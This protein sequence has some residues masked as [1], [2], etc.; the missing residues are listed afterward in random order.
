MYSKTI[1]ALSLALIIT[2]SVPTI[3]HATKTPSF[4]NIVLLQPNG[5]SEPELSIGQ[6]GQVV[7]VAL[8]WTLFQTN[9]WVGAFGQTPTFQG[10]IDSMIQNGIGGGEDADVDFGSTGTV[11]VTS[12]LAVFNPVTNVVQLGVSAITCPNGDLSNNFAKCTRQILDFTQAD[13][14]WI[15]SDGPH[16]WISYHDSGSSTL[17]HVWRSDDD[18]FTWKT[19]GDPIP[20][21][22]SATGNSTF[23]N[24]Q[25][26][27]VADPV[28]HNVYD[29]FAAGVS[30]VQKGT[31]ANFNNIYVSVSTDLGATWTPHL[32]FSAPVN[33]ALNN[34][35]PVLADDPSSG[36]LY[37]G[38]SNLHNVYVSK[39]TNQ[40]STWTAP[41]AV[42]SSPVNTALMP[43]IAVRSGTVDVVYYGTSAASN[44]DSTA[45]WNVYLS[46]S[47]DGGSHF[48]QSVVSSHPN[49][50]GVVCTQGT[51]CARGTRNLLDLFQIGIDPVNGLA[52]IIYTDDTL[53]ILPD[54]SPLP[55]VI[56]AFQT[57]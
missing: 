38:W 35:F 53:T 37:A 27:I 54:G 36:S 28:T 33:Q 12:L 17:I 43:W 55:Q 25:G 11:H 56:F 45:V 52:A 42:T 16:V 21:H 57:S 19:V 41:V 29:I 7:S 13:R 51:G 2:L 6:N 15:T 44:L 14:P 34:I 3:T 24:D 48:A 8:S 1:F 18:G 49:H 10:G 20:G 9:A 47:T 4:T 40:A 23:N 26:K 31:T 32:V 46:R 50:I 5:D 30:G 22:D 39:S